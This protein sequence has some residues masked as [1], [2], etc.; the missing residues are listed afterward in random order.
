[1]GLSSLNEHKNKHNFLD[2]PSDKCNVCNSTENLEHF[3]LYCGCY[4]GARYTLFQNI[5]LVYPNFE[6]LGRKE[7]IKVLLY[8]NT[9]LSKANNK[10]LLMATLSYLRE[11]KHFS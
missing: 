4:A 8:G 2:T 6:L 11:T 5:Q 1:M 7:K 9:S 10:I 3:L